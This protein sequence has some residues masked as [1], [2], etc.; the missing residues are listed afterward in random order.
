M[1]KSLTE[2]DI[3]T[4]YITLAIVKAGW[5]LHRQVREEVSF[6][7]EKIIVRGKLH[8][9]GKSKRA[10]Y[11]L[12]YKPNIPIAVIEAK[13]NNH[14]ISDGMQQALGY[15]DALQI[16]FV[17]SSNGDGFMEHDRTITEGVKEKALTFD[18]ICHVA[19]GQKP[20]TRRERANNVRKLDYFTKYG[21]NAR[22]VLD[23]LL[24]KYAD[25]GIQHIERMD[26]LKVTPF[27]RFGSPVEIVKSFGGKEKYLQALNDMEEL[28]YQVG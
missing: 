1:K 4:Q 18:L 11:I 6:T 15:A 8:S 20:L 23:A 9:R 27:D 10:D 21:E 7:A 26:V 14:S 16:P 19:F 5:D 22:A 2:R 12:Y 3:C 17:Y 28:L 24:D 25:E 13:D